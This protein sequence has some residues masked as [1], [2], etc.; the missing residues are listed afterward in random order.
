MV[1]QLRLALVTVAALCSVGMFG[2]LMTRAHAASAGCSVVHLAGEPALIGCH[3]GWF[4]GYP[5]MLKKGC[6]AVGV[7]AGRQLWSCPNR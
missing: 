6:T 7:S 2:T 4:E 5:N 3:K 1:V